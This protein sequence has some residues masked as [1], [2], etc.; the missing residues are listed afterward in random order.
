MENPIAADVHSGEAEQ[1]QLV[2]EQLAL[3]EKVKE[4]QRLSVEQKKRNAEPTPS[5][6]SVRP[7]MVQGAVEFLTSASV[8]KRRAD[9]IVFLKEKKGLTEAE[10]EAAEKRADAILVMTPEQSPSSSSTP[11]S[12][13]PSTTYAAPH[14]A[15]VQAPYPYPPPALYAPPPPSKPPG[16]LL[17]ALAA[18]GITTLFYWAGK[19][20]EKLFSDPKEEASEK[21]ALSNVQNE[22]KGVEQKV[23]DVGKKVDDIL[24]LGLQHQVVQSSLRSISES[25]TS[26]QKDLGK[27]VQTQSLDDQSKRQFEKKISSLQDEVDQLKGLIQKVMRDSN[28]G[29]VTPPESSNPQ[30]RANVG[31]S[32][33]QQSGLKGFSSSS[34]ISLN[35]LKSKQGTLN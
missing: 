3:K 31:Q 5:S 35:F 29:H 16:I 18:A 32:H 15:N 11:S 7:E 10:I 13:P 6:P 30:N 24:A 2:A 27:L 12:Q 17:P 21:K 19:A 9:A 26:I 20:V 28:A 22:V 14:P 1:T 34:M 4:R 25:Q 23:D 8:R 33:R